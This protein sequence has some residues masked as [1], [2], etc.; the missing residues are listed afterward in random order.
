MENPFA[1]VKAKGSTGADRQRFIDRETI[2]DVLEACPSTAWRTIVALCRFGGL[3]CP[4]EVLSLRWSDVDWANSRIIVTSPKT[5]HHPG[6][7]MRKLPLF[8]EL[9]RYLNEAWEALG[10]TPAEYVVDPK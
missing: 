10:D 7:G 5:E 8:P 6:K 1:D 2:E 4:S 9:R 3:R